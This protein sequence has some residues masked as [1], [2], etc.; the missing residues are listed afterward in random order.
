GQAWAV[1]WTISN[2]APSSWWGVLRENRTGSYDE[3]ARI[4][5]G[6]E[7]QMAWADP[8]ARPGTLRY[9][10]RRE[11]A[12]KRYEWT[13]DRSSLLVGA[14]PRE[15]SLSLLGLTPTPTGARLE[16][17]FTLADGSPATLEVFSV[18]GRR[19]VGRDVSSMGAGDHVIDL[20]REGIR[21]GVY[22][23]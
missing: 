8:D 3:I 5:A 2:S 9:K 19:V 17:A 4:K 14:L 7:I 16:I 21:P 11:C 6:P 15:R 10:I 1:Q 13:S 22:W 12:D 23:I 18:N 20:N